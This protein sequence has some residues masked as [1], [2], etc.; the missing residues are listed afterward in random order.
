M[1]GLDGQ[2]EVLL[3]ASCFELVTQHVNTCLLIGKHKHISPV[4]ELCNVTHQPLLFGDVSSYNLNNLQSQTSSQKL[5]AWLPKGG[6]HILRKQLL[7]LCLPA[8]PK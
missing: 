2:I 4:N 8:K 5:L 1:Q 3:D 6:K 7:M